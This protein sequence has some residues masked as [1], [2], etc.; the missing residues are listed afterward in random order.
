MGPLFFTGASGFIGRRLLA[1]LPPAAA[2][3]RLLSRH[4][5]GLTAA[6][7][8]SPGWRMVAGDLAA[9][10]GWEA[11][12]AGC[13]TVLHLAAA[14]GK[15]RPRTLAAV[16]RDGTERL[17]RAAGAAGVR[18]IILVSSIAAGFT[19]RRY[20]PY[21]ETK[22]QAEGLVLGSALDA[23]VVRPTTV[24]GPGSPT[25]R[26]LRAL[27]TA[28][29]AVCFGNGRVTLQP[30]H[31]DDLVELLARALGLATLGGRIVDAGG[32]ERL[33]MEAL[34][35]RIRRAWTARDGPLVHL[36]AAPVR[37][38]LALLEPALFPLLPLTA[39]QLASFVNEGT[40]RPDPLVAQLHAPS[41]GI[42]AMIA[43]ESARG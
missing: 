22:Q 34:L 3:V 1:A 33:S 43:P 20:Y 38:L 39:G 6:G 17:L 11:A 28:P 10:G 30:I 5:E 26:G 29:V 40:A 13:E 36:P 14:T 42:D 12:L 31:V 7:P 24:F 21:A 19:D 18:R 27:A 8:L 37:H 23:L 25:L 35:R 15:A 4:P 9:P 32:P 2:E 41:R 16:N